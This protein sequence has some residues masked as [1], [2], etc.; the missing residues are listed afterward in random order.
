MNCRWLESISL[1]WRLRN[2]NRDPTMYILYVE[3]VPNSLESLKCM[4]N[5][6]PRVQGLWIEITVKLIAKQYS[7]IL[8]KVMNWRYIHK[9]KIF[10]LNVFINTIYGVSKLWCNQRPWSHASRANHMCLEVTI[11]RFHMPYKKIAC[12]LCIYINVQN[13]H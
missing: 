5:N 8:I 7:S 6:K 1:G 9:P 13:I 2:P 12:I 11:T 4:F 10:F 3:K